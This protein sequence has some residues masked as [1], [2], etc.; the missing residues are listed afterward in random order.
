MII[1]QC[2]NEVFENGSTFP[3]WREAVSK[4]YSCYITF[5]F[6]YF[7][8]V[9]VSDY[10]CPP[11]PQTYT[12][13]I[14]RPRARINTLFS[15]LAGTTRAW[16]HVHGACARMRSA[17]QPRIT[18][19]GGYQSLPYSFNYD[20]KNSVT[21]QLSLVPE[22]SVMRPAYSSH[23]RSVVFFFRTSICLHPSYAWVGG[24]WGL[25]VVSYWADHSIYMTPF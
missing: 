13:S 10:V 22:R 2:L 4:E 17:W 16:L 8:F 21:M 5:F 15:C 3:W 24:G 6:Y 23:S 9:C 14:T 20:P 11:S 19:T 18:Q 7:L 25:G 12:R 1:I